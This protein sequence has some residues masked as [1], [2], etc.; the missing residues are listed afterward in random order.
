MK[1]PRN[2]RKKIQEHP[3]LTDLLALLAIYVLLGG[4][5]T[6][7]MAASICGIF[8]SVLLFI[9]KNKDQFPY[10]EDFYH[11]S[12]I[13]LKKVDKKLKEYA[14]KYKIKHQTNNENLVTERS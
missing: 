14:K 4:T 12:I 3:L 8:V 6:A 1:L 13:I 9:A 5:L 7:I 10:L 2:V 11:I